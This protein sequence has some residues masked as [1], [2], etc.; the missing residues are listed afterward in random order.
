[1][2]VCV[3][4]C[5]HERSCNTTAGPCLCFLRNLIGKEY[6]QGGPRIVTGRC[7]LFIVARPLKSAPPVANTGVAAPGDF[8]CPA[9]AVSF[10]DFDYQD[11][12]ARLF[13][14]LE[15]CGGI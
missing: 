4:V 10:S 9:T 15:V 3:Y 8:N 6:P 13:L 11:I 5:A 14:Y 2:S 7:V 1:M 12:W